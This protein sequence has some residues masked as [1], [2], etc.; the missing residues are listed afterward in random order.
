MDC[1]TPGFSVHHQLPELVQT[2]ERERERERETLP[3]EK[4]R[5]NKSWRTFLALSVSDSFRHGWSPETLPFMRD[6]DKGSR[7]GAFM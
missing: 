3:K 6:S 5:F 1:S 4:K 2:H 7:W